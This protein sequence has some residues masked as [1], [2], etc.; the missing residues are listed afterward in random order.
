VLSS[1]VEAPFV[2]EVVEPSARYLDRV[3][4]G[5]LVVRIDHQVRQTAG[6]AEI[7]VRTTVEGPGAEDVG[8]MVTA[9]T[10]RALE[11]LVAMAEKES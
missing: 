4:V 2:L 7:T 3:T 9:D 11:A 1:G 5:D 10:P 6:G 8:P